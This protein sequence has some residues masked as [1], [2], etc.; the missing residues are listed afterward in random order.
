LSANKESLLEPGNLCGV[1]GCE[2]QAT[3]AV[4]TWQRSPDAARGREP[5]V[6]K[7]VPMCEAHRAEHDSMG[8]ADFFLKHPQT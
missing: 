7:I 5:S 3:S 6:I 1:K 4:T 8:S 2:N